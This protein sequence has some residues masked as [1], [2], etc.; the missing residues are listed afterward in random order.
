MSIASLSFGDVNDSTP[1]PHAAPE[2]QVTAAQPVWSSL[3]WALHVPAPRPAAGDD[4]DAKAAGAGADV[5]VAT[6][7][8]SSSLTRPSAGAGLAAAAAAPYGLSDLTTISVNAEAGEGVV[9][10][11]DEMVRFYSMP[12][13]D[14]TVADVYR[15][16]RAPIAQHYN[17]VP[18]LL[19]YVCVFDKGDSPVW[20][21]K[22]A[23]RGQRDTHEATA[24]PLSSSSSSSSSASYSTDAKEPDRDAAMPIPPDAC[25]DERGI[26]WAHEGALVVAPRFAISCVMNARWLR[27]HLAATLH[28]MLEADESMRSRRVILD[29]SD[30]RGAVLVHGGVSTPVEAAWNN[31]RR[32]ADLA[33]FAWAMLFANLGGHHVWLRSGDRDCIIHSLLLFRRIQAGSWLVEFSSTSETRGLIKEVFDVRALGRCVARQ[34]SLLGLAIG[35]I[36]RGTDW[37]DAAWLFPQVGEPF[38]LAAAEHAFGHP[39]RLPFG[40][41]DDPPDVQLAPWRCMVDQLYWLV[42]K[43]STHAPTR[44]KALNARFAQPY[45]DRVYLEHVRPMVRYWLTVH[46]LLDARHD[47]PWLGHCEPG[48]PAPPVEVP[49]RYNSYTGKKRRGDTRGASPPDRPVAGAS[50]R[51]PPPATKK[52]RT[53]GKYATQTRQQRAGAQSPSD[54]IRERLE[55]ALASESGAMSA[56]SQSSLARRAAPTLGETKDDDDDDLTGLSLD[57][58]SWS[59][60]PLATT[61]APAPRTSGRGRSSRGRLPRSPVQSKIQL[62]PVPSRLEFAAGPL[63]AASG[64]G[65]GGGA[66]AA[67]RSRLPDGAVDRLAHRALRMSSSSSSSSSSCSNGSSGSLSSAM[68]LTPLPAPLPS[69]GKRS[70]RLS[71]ERV[72]MDLSDDSPPWRPRPNA[73]KRFAGSA[74]VHL[75]DSNADLPG[76]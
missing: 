11:S 5:D 17:S 1:P 6:S 67:R 57:L 55:A 25:L 21:D 37:V 59:P 63:A 16:F 40:N 19:Y 4:P 62:V 52:S 56:L 35:V 64:G 49:T 46:D 28:R 75:F 2:S 45:L 60:V 32:E 69:E 50:R 24:R 33:I 38:V 18:A 53:D 61:M 68:S 66:S 3:D 58:A 47:D 44:S 70:G 54:F 48:P 42:D 31:H 15:C 8:S 73:P 9:I 29:Y 71:G 27:A 76:I 65:G 23:T 34:R 10:V 20:R 41:D 30:Q 43:R 39:R 36:C 13:P 14:G 7:S 12:V 74:S 72:T 51:A 22:T 26:F